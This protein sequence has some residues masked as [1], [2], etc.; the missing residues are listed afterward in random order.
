VTTQTVSGGS[1][2]TDARSAEEQADALADTLLQQLRA[3]WKRPDLSI[4]VQPS[5]EGIVL[6]ITPAQMPGEYTYIVQRH[7]AAPALRQLERNGDLDNL[8]AEIL[9][10]MEAFPGIAYA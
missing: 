4:D 10:D 6:S 8:V 1:I 2:Q 3:G 7:L 5:D 9:F